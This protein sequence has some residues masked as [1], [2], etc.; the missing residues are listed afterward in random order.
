MKHRP[1][2]P[3]LIVAVLFILVGCIGFIYLL[4]DISDP[5]ETLPVYYLILFLRL[6]AIVC[7]LL[8]LYRI[9]WARWL[10]I[11]WLAYHVAIS[12]LNSTSE[13]VAHIVLLVIVTVLLFLPVSS[14]FF[15]D[16]KVQ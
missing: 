15:R 6:L 11:A 9:N 8:L 10:T 4:K 2:L 13:M 14:R 1:P 12:A 5:D 7:G 16:K 3:V